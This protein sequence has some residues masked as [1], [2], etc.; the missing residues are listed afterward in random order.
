MTEESQKNER[1]NRNPR[2]LIVDD[3]PDIR[4]L[5]ER[6]LSKSGYIVEV[7][8]NGLHALQRMRGGFMPDLVLCDVRMRGMDAVELLAQV[9]KDEA[10]KHLPFLIMTAFPQR[11][12]IVDATRLGVK[13]FLLKPFQNEDLEGKI[14]SI[15]ATV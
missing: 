2:I 8:V 11:S 15:L 14:L 13:E 3:E 7:A 4:T 10:L 9:R 1:L 6:R 12:L 5:L